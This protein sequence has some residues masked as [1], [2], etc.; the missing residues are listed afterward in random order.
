MSEPYVG[1]IEFFAF[2]FAPRGWVMCQGQLLAI[3]QNQALF[4]LL[5]TTYGGNG[6]TNFQLPDLRSRVPV[7]QGVSSQ[8]Q[9]WVLG[10][11]QGEENH[12]LLIGEMPGH[13]HSLNAV[14]AMTSSNNID[15]PGTTT[16]MGQGFSNSGGTI[17]AANIYAAD[18]APSQNMSGQSLLPSGSSQPHSNLMPGLALNA[19]IATT[20][21]F[22]SRN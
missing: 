20:G 21:L 4:S 13:T 8:G 7:A 5:G 18:T 3:N 14:A 12:L 2:D 17:A 10:E 22:P 1:Q 15:A 9:S 19:C 11:T 6:T 16:V